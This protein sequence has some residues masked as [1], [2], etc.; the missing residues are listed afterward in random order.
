MRIGDLVTL[1]VQKNQ[2]YLSGEGILVEDLYVSKSMKSFE[3]HVFQIYIQRQYSATNELDEFMGR[4]RV[5]GVAS[6]GGLDQAAKNH[7]EA[8]VK[9]K[10]NESVL[11]NSVMKNKTGNQVL[12][13][14]TIQLLHVKSGKF[15]TVLP[16]D[17]ARDERENM[18]VF[19]SPDGSVL[20][21]VKIT[22][23][24]KI[25]REGEP[26]TNNTEVLLKF[27]ERS[28][29]FLH[30]S[31]RNP[32]RGKQ[33]EVNSS[34]DAPTAWKMGTFQ[35]ARDLSNP[36]LLLCGQLVVVKDPELQSV[37]APLP[38]EI[39]KLDMKN[40]S[41][42]G[43]GGGGSDD[44]SVDD[45][46]VT[47]ADEFVRDYGEVVLKPCADALDLDS[48]AIWTAEWKGVTRGG[49]ISFESDRIHLRHFN[50][51]KYLSITW[52]DPSV[53]D[54]AIFSQKEAVFSLKDAPSE[55]D[56][57]F[58]INQLHSS[59]QQLMNSRASQL[60][61]DSGVY[62][63]RGE[64]FDAQKV[65]ACQ[66]I[67]NRGKAVS[68]IVNRYEQRDKSAHR[69]LPQQRVLRKCEEVYD[70]H[71]G[72]AVM[73]HITKFLR[74][75]IIPSSVT[76]D[77]A[78]IWPK[79][80][81]ADRTFFPT[82]ITKASLFVRGYPLAVFDLSP[83]ELSK[84]KTEKSVIVRRQHML[85]QQGL[86]EVLIDMLR[87]LIPISDWLVADSS[88]V[89]SN[90]PNRVGGFMEV[91]KRVL[92]DCLNLL[93]DLIRN[94]LQNQFYI[95]DHL[96]V[97]LAHI[98]TDKTAAKVAQELLSSNRELQDNNIGVKEITAFAD[99]MREIP[100]SAMYLQLLQTCCSCL[101]RPLPPYLL[102]GSSSV[103]LIL[104]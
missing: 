1:K 59:E 61:H 71:F 60:K 35:T 76:H 26:L 16:S 53:P 83:S 95:A 36:A 38:R 15:V 2:S 66:A 34:L 3:E 27:I 78:T 19:L 50:T 90:K 21:W 54:M 8:L 79:M 5:S 48:D 86:V 75:L 65:F 39:R 91:G 87:L 62:L 63:A 85:R 12:F 33:F 84:V 64:F 97:V 96:L 11:N 57:L 42:G 73:Q 72:N 18:R 56:T 68:V 4:L 70:I 41:E 6:N 89:A 28:N 58:Q 74:A 69:L 10:E 14:D 29:E 46:S 30:C 25:N 92:N 49:P 101:V 93:F 45:L 31:E 102:V 43:A 103:G 99:K 17:L 37:L 9:G 7:M 100:M 81:A 104:R 51:G 23:R 55:A 20:S 94:N 67:R 52:R 47:S 24:Y 98:S 40:T 32:P 80:D 77:A 82:I 88:H 13:G 44:F 22:P